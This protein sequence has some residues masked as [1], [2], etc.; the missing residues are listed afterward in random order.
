MI[1]IWAVIYA[2]LKSYVYIHFTLKKY[3]A[4]TATRKKDTVE[5][6]LTA[7]NIISINLMLLPLYIEHCRMNN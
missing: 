4:N 2:W 3:I 7:G 1:F 6:I 5:H